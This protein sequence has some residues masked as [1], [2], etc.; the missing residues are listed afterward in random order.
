[1]TKQTGSGLTTNQLYL[2][3]MMLAQ[4]QHPQIKIEP[5]QDVG[6]GIAQ[7][8]GNIA[9]AV[10]ARRA[11]MQQMQLL[12][13]VF[14]QE[15]AANEQDRLQ[16]VAMLQSKAAYFQKKYV[17]SPEQAL[18]A[19][20][21]PDSVLNKEIDGYQSI[22]ADERKPGV[23]GKTKAAEV[24]GEGTG[25]IQLNQAVGDV[26]VNTP[27]GMNMFHL[28]NG[29]DPQNTYTTGQQ[30]NAFDKGVMENNVYQH[31]APALMQQ[32]L[33][34]NQNTRQ[35]II[36]K[37][38][39]N[40]YAPAQQQATLDSKTTET[41]VQGF[42]LQRL[43]RQQ[44]LDQGLQSGH[45]TPQQ[46]YQGTIMNSA[47]PVSS[48][49]ELGGNKN[50]NGFG[51]NKPQGMVAPQAPAPQAQPGP[52]TTLLDFS[53]AGD[54]V[55]QFQGLSPQEQAN[56]AGAYRQQLM[57]NIGQGFAPIGQGLQNAASG[58]YGAETTAGNLF[59]LPQFMM[60][61]AP[62]WLQQQKPSFGT[63]GSW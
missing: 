45:I 32:P 28:I 61:Q 5:V 58:L 39:E 36:G 40:Q 24:L 47:N 59:G 4:Q 63:S 19:A 44:V 18:Q 2:M 30:Q 3:R 51:F 12:Q 8:I 6:S 7:G 23:A 49:S 48:L 41:G 10:Q 55:H 53:N 33:L 25:K 50:L 17:M 42:Q 38:I 15:Q 46:Y 62:P 37:G 13:S 54:T 14:A 11:N 29:F 9:N 35:Q 56:Q 16:K 1:M 43:Q 20:Q 52:P 21:L 60:P 31:Q 26:N 57:G 27:H 34:E 22:A